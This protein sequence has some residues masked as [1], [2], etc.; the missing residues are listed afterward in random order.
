MQLDNLHQ[1]V[2][3]TIAGQPVVPLETLREAEQVALQ[4][5]QQQL[6]AAGGDRQLTAEIS[7]QAASSIA[8]IVAGK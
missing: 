3:E 1:S 6:V 5:W 4:E 8:W 2:R 7:I